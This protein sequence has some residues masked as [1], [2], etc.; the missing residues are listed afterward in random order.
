MINTLQSLRFVFAIMIFFHHYV[1]NGV[2]LF[3]AGGPCGVSFFMILSGFVMSAGYGE[4]VLKPA[5]DGKEFFIKRL[6]RLYPLHVLCLLGFIVLNIMHLSA[7]DYIK[8]LPNVLLLQ[9]WVPINS[10]YF[11][12]NAVSWCLTDMMFFYAMFPLLARLLNYGEVKKICLYFSL[13]LAIYFLIIIFLPDIYCH[14][15]LYISPAFRLIDFFIG[16]LMFKIYHELESKGWG[17]KIVSWSYTKKSGI[18][19]L[20][21]LFLVITIMV[22]PHLEKR[23]YYAALWWIIIPETVLLFALFNKSGGVISTLLKSKWMLVSGEI[24]FSL[25]MIHQ[26]GIGVILSV[27]TKLGIDIPWQIEFC[28]CFLLILAASYIVYHYYEIPVSQYLKKKLI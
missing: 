22:A 28:V 7:M 4:K 18:E 14:R 2:G 11:S 10:I 9:S 6:I 17:G 15:L 13:L 5:F 19:I 25:Y 23:Y 1:V 21:I 16:M 3:A 8:L 24:S 26:M 20:F 12:G 27:F